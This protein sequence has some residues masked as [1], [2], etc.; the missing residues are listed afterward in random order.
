MP[1]IFEALILCSNAVGGD[2]S[3]IMYRVIAESGNPPVFP[4][5]PPPGSPSRGAIVAFVVPGISFAATPQKNGKG[6]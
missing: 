2:V 4:C 3:K 5:V 6:Q 1:A